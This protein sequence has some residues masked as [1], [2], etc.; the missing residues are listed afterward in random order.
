MTH[1]DYDL[2]VIGAGSGGVRA[3]RI[4]ATH[5]ARVAIAEEFRVGGT[6]VIRG[7]VPKKLYVIASRFRDEFE[8]AKGFGWRLD[9]P[10]FDWG[11]LVAA[12]E[13]EISRLE[14][15]YAQNLVKAGVEI[16][17]QRA[18]VEGAHAVRLADGATISAEKILIATGGAP[19]NLDIPGIELALSS[20][21]IFDCDRF[22][23]R[24]LIIGAGYIAVEFAAIFARLGAKV[25]MSYRADLPLR[26]FDRELRRL[27]AEALSQSGVDL[28]A[29][30]TP[31]R[32][33]RGAGG[34]VAE[35]ANGETREFDAVLAATGRAPATN[36][37]GLLAAGVRL[38]KNGAVCV[39]SYSRS[40]VESIF[41]VG[42]VTDRINLTPVAI[43]EGHAFADT[44]FGGRDVK[45]DYDLV[46]SAVF[47]TPEIGTVGCTEE[48]A[49]RRHGEIAV[50]E[51]SFRPIKATLSGRADKVFMKLL[52]D[53]TSEIVI[54]AHILGPEAGEM[55]QLIAIPMKMGAKK[56]DFDAAMALH[57][58]MAEELVTM[59]APS[60]MAKNLTT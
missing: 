2:F 13:K 52:V 8:D 37:L 46:P 24:L 16:I 18:V 41:A 30:A 35:F 56:S 40:S 36:G 59:R 23:Q 6:C 47:T 3:A 31:K 10:S 9:A 44:Q 1:Y 17:R 50:Y 42:D 60:R 34:L 25:A 54:G 45:V 5:G 43:R 14:G 33:Q 7:C 51:T 39:D 19:A 28:L 55:A 12:K 15:L 49:L 21:E 58:T 48:E 32:L 26:G 22:P 27:L 20:N 4:A 57:P 38:Q 29:G 53:A 11:G